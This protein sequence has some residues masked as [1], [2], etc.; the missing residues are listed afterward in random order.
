MNLFYLLK[1]KSSVAYL[2]KTNTIRQGLEKM[3]VHGYSAIPVIDDN[4]EYIGTV[5]EGD[6][7]WH[8]LK[9]KKEDIK[10]QEQYSILDIVNEERNLPVKINVTMDE[11]LLRVMDQNFV[12]VIDDR[13]MFIGI[14]TRKDIIKYFYDKS[15]KDDSDKSEKQ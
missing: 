3:R 6:F 15:K 12:P 10:S 4:G 9:Y 7:L 1:P 13:N 14:I 5:S 2:Y 8:I 11:L